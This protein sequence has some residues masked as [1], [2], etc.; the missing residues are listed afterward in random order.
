MGGGGARSHHH[1]RSKVLIASTQD[2]TDEQ[3]NI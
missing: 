3:A 1:A 2:E